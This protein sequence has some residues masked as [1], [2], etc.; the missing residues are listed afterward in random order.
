MNSKSSLLG[1]MF[2][3][4]LFLILISLFDNS[5]YSQTQQSIDN[6][7]KQKTTASADRKTDSATKTIKEVTVKAVKTGEV[8][9]FMPD[10]QGTKIYSG[11]KTSVIDLKKY[12]DIQNNNYRE[13]LIQ[14]PGLTLSE[15]QTPLVSIGYRGLNPDRAQFMMLLKDGIPISADMF[16]Y[17][18]NY[19]TPI[20]QSVDDIQFIR[21]GSALLY[22]PQP[23]GA[24]NYITKKPLTNTPFLAYS[25]N[26]FGSYD[27]FS[28]Y[29][30]VT[31]TVGKLGYYGYFHERQSEGFRTTNSDYEVIAGSMKVVINQQ[32]K[33]RLT[34]AYD[35]YH[36]HHGEPG[37]LTLSPTFSPNYN[38][39]RRL[40]TREFDRF[41]LERYYG[42]GILEK[43]FS[44]KTKFELRVYG[45][46]YRRWS[47][48]QR[49]GG[50]GTYPTLNSNDIQDQYFYNLGFE[51][52]FKHQYELLGGTHTF[53]LG[54]HTFFSDSPRK[55]FRGNSPQTEEGQLRKNAARHSYYFSVFLENLFKWGPLSIVPG[56]R[57][58]NFWQSIDE[59]VN[60]DKTTVPLLNKTEYE[61]A[62][63]F[64]LG[65]MYEVVKGVEA[66]VNISQSYR[67]MTFT[68]TV[69]TGTNQVVKGDLNEGKGVQYD[70]G[71]RGK[72]V[73]FL[74]WDVDY[75]ILTF[76][77]QI[78]TVGNS[79]QD[80][81][82][83]LNQGMELST[84][85]DLVGAVD[86]FKKSDYTS[87]VG[88]ISPFVAYTLL[89][90]K[91]DKGFNEGRVPAFAPRF[92]VKTGFNYR[93]RDRVKIS[94]FATFVDDQFA[95]DAQ[96][97]NRIVPSYKVW[98]LLAEMNLFRNVF[99]SFDM[100]L[101]GGINN[102]WD[103][104][105]YS[106]ITSTGIDP[107]YPRNLY[108]GVK[109]SWGFN[110]PSSSKPVGVEPMA[111]AR[112]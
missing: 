2:L 87:L 23:G 52:R 84:E 81:G 111:G 31:G 1:K 49:G 108:G 3:F 58:E 43:D 74:N 29:N 42:Y 75:F 55:E 68:E 97:P 56:M 34:L 25:E 11:K 16:G 19:Y 5:V 73:P 66:Y 98:D 80:V 7:E 91:F 15:E 70:F 4:A 60:L 90:A 112:Y 38:Q 57:F 79:I 104:K 53:T 47:K 37:G 89:D 96:T 30:A 92:T 48:R 78:G 61:F 36:E 69:P 20:I 10:V 67:P 12:P 76:K 21:G 35:E 72:P 45:G 63:L 109:I 59:K 102:I 82:D 6:Q 106:R 33:T 100:S 24:L 71:L 17:P 50:F 103:E 32:G 40:A 28:T 26:S 83:L 27:Y 8:G 93:W 14:Q 51:P 94:L 41:E 39:N 22:G 105:Y 18:E 54:T 99:N 46:K 85:V 86:Y 9:P 64:G 77:D 44:E 95:D 107:A 13:I 62:P 65:L 101:F 110:E 88:S